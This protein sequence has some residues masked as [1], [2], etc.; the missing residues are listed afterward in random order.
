M[1]KRQCVL[2]QLTFWFYS[3][4]SFAGACF[5]VNSLLRN[6]ATTLW[7]C[8]IYIA[9][10]R[11]RLFIKIKNIINDTIERK[12]KMNWVDRLKF[13]KSIL[14]FSTIEFRRVVVPLR[15]RYWIAR[16]MLLMSAK[17]VS[18]HTHTY[19]SRCENR[20]MQVILRRRKH[21]ITKTLSIDNLRRILTSSKN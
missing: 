21:S 11:K 8:S 16:W 12:K 14:Q 7:Q 13:S 17:K 4:L 15:Q 2:S 1:K 5:N 19:A 10:E 9:E 3:L 20:R 18:T 6:Y